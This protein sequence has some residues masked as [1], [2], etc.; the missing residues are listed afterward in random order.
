MPNTEEIE[1]KLCAYVDGEL[2]ASGVAE[3]ERHLLANP[4]HK[5]LIT[6]LM[7]ARRYVQ[8]LPRAS[9]PGDLADAL[10]SQLERATL[11][12]DDVAGGDSI[13]R[14]GHWQQIRAIAAVLVL[15]AGLAA[16]LYYMLP[17]PRTP[18]PEIALRSTTAGQP[19]EARDP[20]GRVLTSAGTPDTQ[21]HS[22]DRAIEPPPTVLAQ[23]DPPAAAPTEIASNAPSAQQQMLAQALQNLHLSAPQAEAR[24]IQLLVTARDPDAARDQIREWLALNNFD[25]EVVTAEPPPVPLVLQDAQMG[26]GSRLQKKSVEPVN[27][28]AAAPEDESPAPDGSTQAPARDDSLLSQSQ[29][30]AR[31][32]NRA[33]IDALCAVV[34]SHDRQSATVVAAPASPLQPDD[35]AKIKDVPGHREADPST[36]PSVLQPGMD[37]SPGHQIGAGV[38]GPA[39]LSQ[40]QFPQMQGEVRV[41]PAKQ[42]AAAASAFADSVIPPDERVTV[43]I[44]IQPDAAMDS[45]TTA[46]TTAPDVLPPQER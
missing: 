32:M 38:P 18:D 13:M 17:S 9:A 14:I 22:R 33:E 3:I 23:A 43:V 39:Q 12:G 28:L 25:S 37:S 34:R 19:P 46:P 1:A 40:L 24:E 11:L 15:A 31:A 44:V 7:R 27:P 10:G 6:D 2:D 16:I 5:G 20:V 8:E 26:I 45:P 21:P 4:E 42:G 30:R 36:E 41:A 29:I 35:P